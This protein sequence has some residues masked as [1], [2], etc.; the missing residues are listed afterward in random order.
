MADENRILNE[1]AY[2]KRWKVKRRTV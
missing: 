2:S 1:I